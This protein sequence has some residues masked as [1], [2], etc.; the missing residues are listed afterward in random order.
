MYNF[1]KG[2]GK[3]SPPQNG[4]RGLQKHQAYAFKFK[5]YVEGQAAG[6]FAAVC[7]Y[8]KKKYRSDVF[9]LYNNMLHTIK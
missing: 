5:Y 8:L 9:E 7:S 2:V 1:E 3:K 6:Q 4:D